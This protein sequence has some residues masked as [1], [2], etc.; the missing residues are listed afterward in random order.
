MGHAPENTLAS[1]ELARKMGAEFVEC[2]VHLTKDN[3]VVVIHDETVERTTNSSGPVRGFTL[4]QIKRLDAGSWFS[5]KF[6][7]EKVPTLEELLT[8]A[9]RHTSHKGFQMGVAIEVK[10]DPVR[11]SKIA[12]ETVGVVVKTGM[13]SRVIL[14]SFDHAVVKKAKKLNRKIA[15]GILFDKE[16]KDP[17][18]RAKEVGADALFPRRNLVTKP[19]VQK[20]HQKGLAVA[21]WTVNEAPDMKKIIRCG[22]DAIATNY[23]ERLNEILSVQPTRHSA[24]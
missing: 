5:K 8:W 4:K 9:K 19:L 15:T 14:I 7:G 17:F 13:V 12:E 18:K 2:D 23:P 21:T 1:F 20:A 3:Q 24:I 6:K 10:N 22:A 16:L 11:Y